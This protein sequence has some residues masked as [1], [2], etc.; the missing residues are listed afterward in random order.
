MEN[1]SMQMVNDIAQGLDGVIVEFVNNYVDSH[2]LLSD[3][4]IDRYDFKNLV[5]VALKQALTKADSTQSNPLS[6]AFRA[7]NKYRKNK[8]ERWYASVLKSIDMDTN[9]PKHVFYNSI[10]IYQSSSAKQKQTL[11]PNMTLDD[12][13]QNL[14]EETKTWSEDASSYLVSFPGILSF[15]KDKIYSSVLSDVFIDAFYYIKKNYAG[16]IRNYRQILPDSMISY[17]FFGEKRQTLQLKQTNDMLVEKLLLADDSIFQTV[18]HPS[19]ANG[20]GSIGSPTVQKSF[21]Q[22]DLMFFQDMFSNIDEEFYNSRTITVPLLNFAKLINERPN[23]QYL[24]RAVER[25]SNYTD[26]SFNYTDKEHNIVLDKYALIDRVRI[27]NPEGYEATD[28]Y[29]FAS[30]AKV[31]I[32]FADKL[33]EEI[34]N[35]QLTVITTSSLALVDSDL[36][37]L[38]CPVLQR[39]RTLLT[40]TLDRTKDVDTQ[41][42]KIYRY[43]FFAKSVRTLGVRKS[44]KNIARLSDSLKEFKDASLFI[45]S[46][47][48]HNDTFKITYFPLTDDE[49]KDIDFHWNNTNTNAIPMIDIIDEQNSFEL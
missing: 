4:D 8:K 35:E 34:V 24:N 3:E 14:V 27:I 16:N 38:L 21:D 36:S 39:E 9:N 37:R 11:F 44:A 42:T 6:K 12:V 13:I 47:V 7:E 5:F 10:L 19:L 17:P 20:D 41:M 15:S 29:P 46:I 33:Y 31:I 48:F 28:E 49:K 2:S 30:D 23:K 43:T 40:L 18:I 22:I 1:I 32:H 45:K 25:L 26:K